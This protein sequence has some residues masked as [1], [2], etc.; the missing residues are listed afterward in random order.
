MGINRELCEHEE[1]T[2]QA[3]ILK[4]KRH[5][6]RHLLASPEKRGPGLDRLNHCRDLDPR[7]AE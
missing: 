3:F 7:Y 1:K 4:E 6:F 2:I 5:R